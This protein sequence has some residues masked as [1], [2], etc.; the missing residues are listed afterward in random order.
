MMKGTCRSRGWV[1]CGGPIALAALFALG[2]AAD[3]T[4]TVGFTLLFFA[5]AVRAFRA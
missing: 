2:L 4:I 3:L 5:L 1:A